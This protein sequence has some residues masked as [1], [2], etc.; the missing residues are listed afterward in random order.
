[1]I[2]ISNRIFKIGSLFM[3][4]L[5]LSCGEKEVKEE[6]VLRP[7]K[8]SEVSYLGGDITRSFSGAA[9]TLIHI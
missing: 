4:F 9:L 5:L 6:V 1:M 2:M 7:V 3:V 8:F